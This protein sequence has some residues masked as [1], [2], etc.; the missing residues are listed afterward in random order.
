MVTVRAL[1]LGQHGITVDA[2]GIDGAVNER[3]LRDASQYESH[4]T[5][6]TPTGRYGYPEDVVASALLYLVS[7]E[8]RMLNGHTLLHNATAHTAQ[9]YGTLR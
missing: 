9:A 2:L 1:E 4:W 6:V 5:G 7:P 3:D 8:A